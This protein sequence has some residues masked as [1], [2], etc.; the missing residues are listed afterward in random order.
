MSV[1]MLADLARRTSDDDVLVADLVWVGLT[2]AGIA[3][4]RVLHAALVHQRTTIAGIAEAATLA[5]TILRVELD[6]RG[7]EAPSWAVFVEPDAGGALSAR[8][9]M[10]T[11]E[12]GLDVSRI[13]YTSRALLA[14]LHRG[15]S[16]RAR[17]R[18]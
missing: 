8:V 4:G 11:H 15:M 3:A 12:D 13:A 16:Y 1:P 5:T 14:G 18:R 10:D 9:M 7:V 17:G 2:R 6:R